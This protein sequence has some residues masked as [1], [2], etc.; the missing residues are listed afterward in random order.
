MGGHSFK[1]YHLPGETAALWAYDR[2][3][4]TSLKSYPEVGNNLSLYPLTISEVTGLITRARPR[5]SHRFTRMGPI[6]TA[7]WPWFLKDLATWHVCYLARPEVS[8]PTGR[9]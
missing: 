6:D 3:R 8:A 5:I 9:F 1:P 4:G 2:R 7:R